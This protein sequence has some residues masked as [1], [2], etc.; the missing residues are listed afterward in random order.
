MK[1]HA[2]LWEQALDPHGKSWYCLSPRL[3]L[4]SSLSAEIQSDRFLQTPNSLGAL[5]TRHS[6]REQVPRALAIENRMYMLFFA[7]YFASE[8]PFPPFRTLEV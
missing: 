2:V 4:H 6:C 1:A 5:Y 3:N 8:D 7:L